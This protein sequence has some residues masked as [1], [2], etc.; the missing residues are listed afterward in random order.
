[1]LRK[2]WTKFNDTCFVSIFLQDKRIALVWVKISMRLHNAR[3]TYLLFLCMRVI[4]CIIIAAGKLMAI[5]IYTTLSPLCFF[6]WFC[7]CCIIYF[8]NVKNLVRRT[9]KLII[10]HV[11][12]Q[13]CTQIFLAIGLLKRLKQSFVHLPDVFIWKIGWRD[14]NVIF[15]E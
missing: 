8:K 3:V 4:T 11:S 2:K 5:I 1:M 7:L 13:H 14:L 6:A 9:L 12:K 15:T 10:L